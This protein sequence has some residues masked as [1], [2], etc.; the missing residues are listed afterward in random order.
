[1]YDEWGWELYEKFEEDGRHAQ[2]CMMMCLTEPDKALD[3]IEIIDEHREALLMN[4]RKKMATAPIKIRTVFKLF[5]FTFE[6]V[7]AIK[8]A[9]LATKEQTSD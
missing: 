5:C 6:G 2:D 1:M 9:L 7:I 8:E 4:I 3:G